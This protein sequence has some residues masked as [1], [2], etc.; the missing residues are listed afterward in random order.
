MRLFFGNFDLQT[1]IQNNVVI[2]SKNRFDNQINYRISPFQRIALHNG[3]HYP[4]GHMAL[5][6]KSHTM[7]VEFGTFCPHFR[8]TI[9]NTLML[10]KYVS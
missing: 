9:V 6:T 2:S 8:I 5:R 4:Q 3:T 1:N 10:T 7:A